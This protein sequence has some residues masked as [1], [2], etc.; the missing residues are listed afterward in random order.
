MASPSFWASRWSHLRQPFEPQVRTTSVAGSQHT[1]NMV[2]VQSNQ[3]PFIKIG[4]AFN[5]PH[6]KTAARI[7]T[8]NSPPNP[9]YRHSRDPGAKRLGTGSLHHCPGYCSPSLGLGKLEP[10]VSGAL[11]SGRWCLDGGA[12]YYSPSLGLLLTYACADCA[13]QPPRK[14]ASHA[15]TLRSGVPWDDVTYHGCK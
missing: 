1:L 6:H 11:N 15:G 10:S 5:S 13:A 9:N 12:G 14:E 8:P 7:R 4:T 3:H 2:Q